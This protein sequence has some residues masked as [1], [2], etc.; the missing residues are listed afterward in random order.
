M[1]GDQVEPDSSQAEAMHLLSADGWTE[2]ADMDRRADDATKDQ[3]RVETAAYTDE[4]QHAESSGQSSRAVVVDDASTS[5]EQPVEYKVYKIR[6]FGLMQLVL[7][8]IVVSWDVSTRVFIKRRPSSMISYSGFPSPPS[9]T[10]QLPTSP[11][12]PASSTG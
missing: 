10:Q 9:P 1:H 4:V 2:M 12:H 7:L 8:N 6:W 11:P 5:G 3:S